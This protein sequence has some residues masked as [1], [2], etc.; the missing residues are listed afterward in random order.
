[1]NAE[2]RTRRE[3]NSKINITLGNVDFIAYVISKLMCDFVH[4]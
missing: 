4:D 3:K 1:M 2:K